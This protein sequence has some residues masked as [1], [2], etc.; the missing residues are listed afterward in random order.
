MGTAAYKRVVNGRRAAL[1]L[2]AW[3]MS[4]LAVMLSLFFSIIVALGWLNAL[5]DGRTPPGTAYFA[6]G[7]PMAWG[8]LAHMT[9]AWVGERPVHRAWPLLGLLVGIPLAV[10]SH[11]L[12]FLYAPCFLLALWLSWYHLRPTPK[13]EARLPGSD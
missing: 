7:I 13:G 1:A 3:V 10:V 11:K 9:L 5:L 12:W 4:S 2:V 8:V 6:L